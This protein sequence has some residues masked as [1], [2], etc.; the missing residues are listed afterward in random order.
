MRGLLLLAAV[1]LA[2]PAVAQVQIPAPEAANTL[3]NRLTGTELI[4]LD[5]AGQEIGR[6]AL[7]STSIDSSCEMTFIWTGDAATDTT[8][9]LGRIGRLQGDGDGTI[10]ATGNAADRPTHQF[11]VGP[12][13]YADTL[14]AFETMANACD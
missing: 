4:L 11:V 3:I 9:H 13:R 12:A 5:A 8:I 14:Q 2:G 10:S 6:G 7:L 1:A